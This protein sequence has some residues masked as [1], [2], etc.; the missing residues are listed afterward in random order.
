MQKV[1]WV[2]DDEQAICWALKKGI[3]QRGYLCKSFP[4]AETAIRSLSVAT[5]LDAVLLDMRMPGMD[6][7]EATAAIHRLQPEVPIVMMTAFGDLSSAIQAMDSGI[8]EYL[9]KPF[10]LDVALRTIERAMQSSVQAPA[11]TSSQELYFGSLL[12]KSPAMQSVYKQIAVASK[13]D[14]SVHVGG[15]NGIGKEAVASAIHRHSLRASNPFLVYVPRAISPIALSLELL[16]SSSN[17]AKNPIQ[18]RSGALELAGQGVLFIDEVADLP[19]TLQTQ[20]LRVL[21]KGCYTPVGDSQIRTCSARVI[22]STE[23]D[24]KE[25]VAEGEFLE[26]LRQRLCVF[27]IE[28]QSLQDRREDIVPIARDWLQRQ[29]QEVQA[30]F[31]SEAEVWLE[32]QP[33]PGNIRELRSAVARAL[34]LARDGQIQVS[35]LQEAVPSHRSA[36]D[37]ATSALE[38]EI[39]RW[40]VAHLKHLDDQ[41]LRVSSGGQGDVFGD[42]Y[43][44]F[45]GAVERP[46]L[47]SM[48]QAFKNNRATIAAQ[49]GLHRS[50][51][52][53]KLRRYKID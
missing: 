26:E 21:E 6:G 13:G 15:P 8:V 11:E 17:V 29:S 36:N 53:Q 10:D 1:I 9:T 46:L 50:T 4:N 24:L 5:V 14:T 3:E 30:S 34:V 2:I 19:L 12:G 32:S 52:R 23:R 43:E 51:L 48:M 40:T 35:D 16:G 39:E 41:G 25:L 47:E 42:M 22:T 49:L 37:V 7:F 33:W 45:L 44:D 18:A 20:L 28:L 27:V 38:H 31:S